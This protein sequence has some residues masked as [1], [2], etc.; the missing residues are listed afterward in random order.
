MCIS[1]L[2]SYCLIEEWNKSKI[3]SLVIDDDDNDDDDPLASAQKR[4]IGRYLGIRQAYNVQNWP[5]YAFEILI[6]L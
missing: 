3:A 5:T 1:N 4:Q 6:N 2:R